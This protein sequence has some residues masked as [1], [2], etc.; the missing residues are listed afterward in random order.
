[1]DILVNTFFYFLNQ[2][3]FH[4]IECNTNSDFTQTKQYIYS[5]TQLGTLTQRLILNRSTH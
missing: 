1:M 5:K 2:I 4:L 3:L